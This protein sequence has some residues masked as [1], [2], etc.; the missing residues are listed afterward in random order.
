V[1]VFLWL[2]ITVIPFGTV[3]LLCSLFVDSFKLWWWIANPWLRLAI[4]AT[5]VIGGVDYRVIGM[6]N[7]PAPDD[8]QRIIL[9]P[10]HQ[11]TW[12]TFFFP[13]MMSHPL[14]YVFKQELLW[15]PFF[16]WAMARLEMVHID[17]SARSEAWNKV[18]TLGTKL[19][20]RGKWIIMFPEGTRTARG[21]RGAYKTGASRLALATGA[22]IVPI[23]VASGRCWPRRTW[24]FIPG[25]IDVSIGP[26]IEARPD[27]SA[28]DLMA[29]VEEWI[30]NEMVRIDPD[31][32][33][34]ARA[35]SEE[36]T[37]ADTLARQADAARASGSESID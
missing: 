34:D 11:S 32:Y 30:E 22:K 6:E 37:Q 13:S 10:K 21:E 20:D 33:P 29:R 14:A 5:K 25:T 24:R 26:A 23:A 35:T 18:A 3:I 7:L 19:M 31:A 9:C 1:A 4:G 12:E 36:N 15:I 28:G 17:R 27:E 2:A 16:G 8:N